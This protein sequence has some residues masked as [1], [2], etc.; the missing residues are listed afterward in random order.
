M[1]VLVKVA[2]QGWIESEPWPM[3]TLHDC[4]SRWDSRY[5]WCELN[6]CSL[7]QSCLLRYHCA[8]PSAILRNR[9]F[10]MIIQRL[11]SL[12]RGN[13]SIACQ[14]NL[15]ETRCQAFTLRQ[16]S[17]WQ[18]IFY[19]RFRMGIHFLHHFVRAWPPDPHVKNGST[20]LT[21]LYEWFFNT[22]IY[23]ILST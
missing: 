5:K 10:D 1:S 19:F 6:H 17:V 23:S 2:L 20:N 22:C 4:E 21:C 9:S 16:N 7:S 14:F 13:S 3:I 15:T 8:W 18:L 11:S 12:H